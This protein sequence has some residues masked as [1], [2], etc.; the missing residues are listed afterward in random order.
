MGIL[1]TPFRYLLTL[2]YLLTVLCVA[3]RSVGLLLTSFRYL[4]NLV[5]LLAFCEVRVH[6]THTPPLLTNPRSLTNLPLRGGEERGA[7]GGAAEDGERGA[8]AVRHLVESAR[9]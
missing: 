7:E 4:L 3:A 6:I 9:G 8:A 1:L 2:V 5:Y